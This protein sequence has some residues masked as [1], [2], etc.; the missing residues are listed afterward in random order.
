M[1]LCA[2]SLYLYP[3]PMYNIYNPGV[4]ALITRIQKPSEALK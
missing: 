1:Q 3:G 4:V 2:G